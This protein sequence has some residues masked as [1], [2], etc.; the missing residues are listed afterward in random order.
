MRI[1]Q[2]VGMKILRFDQGDRLVN[3]IRLSQ[4]YNSAG[5]LIL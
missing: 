2:A 3:S 1:F 5:K 4:M